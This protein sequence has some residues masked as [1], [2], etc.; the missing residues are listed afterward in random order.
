[1]FHVAQDEKRRVPVRP[2]TQRVWT[3]NKA[4]LIDRYLYYFLRVAKRGTYV[5]GF[6]GPHEPDIPDSWAAKRVLDSQPPVHSNRLQLRHFHLCE[7]GHEQFR[8][9]QVLREEHR[10]RDITLWHGDFNKRVDEL[11]GADS[12]SPTEATFV[13]LDQYAFECQWTTVEKL[14]RYQH[15]REYKLEQFYFLA[16]WW[17]QRS[18]RISREK[19]IQWWGRDDYGNLFG[20]RPDERATIL[21]DRFQDEL[22]YRFATAWPIYVGG[23]AWSVAYHMVHATD[24]ERA[25]ELMDDA[26]H[27]LDSEPISKDQLALRLGFDPTDLLD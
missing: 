27:G 1:M 10:E 16:Q 21:C 13:L 2:P 11:L 4:R 24:H 15:P 6:A 23:E 3:R 20:C 17:F 8:R 12:I 9:L 19:A 22:G 7:R 18:K 14:A 25:P 26:Y 5:D